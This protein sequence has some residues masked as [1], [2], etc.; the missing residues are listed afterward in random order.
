M[1]ML[2]TGHKREASLKAKRED[3]FCFSHLGLEV[4]A[5]VERSSS[6]PY[7]EEIFQRLMNTVEGSCGKL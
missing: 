2:V 5:I 3:E 7:K 1:V 4:P 6:L